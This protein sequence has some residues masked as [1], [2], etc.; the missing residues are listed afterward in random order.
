LKV[1]NEDIEGD[2]GEEGDV[3]EEK[4]KKKGKEAVYISDENEVLS[5]RVLLKKK[6]TIE[7]I[8]QNNVWEYEDKAIGMTQL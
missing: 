3:G 1:E 7:A 8:V 4:M 5:I 6:E 2:E